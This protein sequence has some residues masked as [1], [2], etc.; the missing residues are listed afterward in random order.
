MWNW[1]W[2]PGVR[3]AGLNYLKV[4]STPINPRSRIAFGVCN[5]EVILAGSFAGLEYFDCFLQRVAFFEH[6]ANEESHGRALPLAEPT[7]T[8]FTD[9]NLLV[10]HSRH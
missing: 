4:V 9:R 1:Y 5:N 7:T 8:H 2:K 10:V 6:S 3:L